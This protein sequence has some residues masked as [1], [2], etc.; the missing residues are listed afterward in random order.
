MS[1][2]SYAMDI[3]F[4]PVT[5]YKTI[6]TGIWLGSPT[7]SSTP[8]R[9]SSSSIRPSSGLVQLR[10]IVSPSTVSSSRSTT[11]STYS[12]IVQPRRRFQ[13]RPEITTYIPKQVWSTNLSLKMNT[14]VSTHSRL[15]T[16]SILKISGFIPR[17]YTKT[18]TFYEFILVDTKSAKITHVL[19]KNDPSKIVFS[20]IKIFK[21]LNP[22]N[23]NRSLFTKK[24]FFKTICPTNIQLSR[25]LQS[26]VQHVLA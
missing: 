9:P 2:N 12:T 23:W 24:I 5:R 8:P 22:T 11:P 16:K 14:K 3:G 19:D 20:K 26:M 10:P 1:S 15:F 4:T 13:P 18:C 17:V 21:V 7:K 25:L 6:S